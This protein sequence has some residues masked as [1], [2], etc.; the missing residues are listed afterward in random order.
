MPS[1][2]RVN[3]ADNSIRRIYGHSLA[4]LTDL[5]QL[6]M[7][8][9]YWKSGTD[10]KDAVFHLFFRRQ[11]FGGG[12]SVACGLNHVIDYLGSF[13]FDD[14]DVAY[15]ATLEGTDG[16][17][18]FES[19]FLDYLRRLELRCDVSAVPEG[20]VV[21]PREPLI[22]VRGP[23]LHCQ[24]IETAILNIVNF[25][26]LIATKASRV[27]AAAQGDPVLEFGLR[28]AQGIDGGLSASWAAHVGGCVATSNLLAGK[29]YGI[30]VRG[31]HAHSW[32]MSFPS[33][34]EAFEVYAKALPN[35][36]VFLVDTYNT[37]EGVRRAVEV[38]RWL[39][40][41]GQDL[42]GIRLDSGDLQ[43]LSVATRKVLDEAGFTSTAILA[44]NDLDE[45][46]IEKLKQG[47][48]PI[49]LWGVGTKL[50]TAFDEPALGGVYKVTAVKDSDGEWC[51]KL[52]VSEEGVKTS[53]PG[54]QPDPTVLARFG[55]RR[56]HDLR[57]GT[58]G[59][60][61]RGVCS[62]RTRRAVGAPSRWLSTFRPFGRSPETG[63]AC[64]RPTRSPRDTA[65]AEDSTGG[66][67]GRGPATRPAT[68]LSGRLGGRALRTEARSGSAGG[69][70][71][72][73]LS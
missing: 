28:R 22:R 43:Q 37:V 18:L 12:Y 66:P 46:S 49:G 52:K 17:A 59:S 19:D 62:G 6:T 14:D 21:F 30:P 48:A 1:P 9:G 7:A 44:T 34:Q 23:I 5:Y 42:V 24:I 51:Y 25:Q 45:R 11:P 8:Y 41:R 20:T 56:R 38:G 58:W 68:V 50:V 31:T 61:A 16:K 73:L 64:L 53:D 54:I 2:R 67:R 55:V 69:S 72:N 29:L 15:L 63:P 10:Q 32:V 47:G 33:E 57:R 36:C 39:R 71:T 4:L 35:N 3:R 26:T 70:G 27:V 65:A 13:E 60:T 40:Q